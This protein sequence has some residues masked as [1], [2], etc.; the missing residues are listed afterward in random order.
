MAAVVHAKTSAKADGGDSTLVQPSDWNADHTITGLTTV[1]TDAIWD[2]A[3][4][5]AVGSGAD[6]AARLAKGAAG[7]VLAMG[8]GAVIWNAGTSFPASKA[9]GDRYYRTDLGMDFYY[10]GT[11]WLSVQ[12]FSLAGAVIDVLQP[13]STTNTS[14]TFAV[15]DEGPSSVGAYVTRIVFSTLV[16]GTN[17]GSHYWTVQACS[18]ASAGTLHNLGSSF[19][20]SADSTSWTRHVVSVG[21]VVTAGDIEYRAQGTKTG[22]PGGL[23]CLMAIYY[24]L[25][26]T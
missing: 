10:D 3:G 23:Y 12:E 19:A 14:A 13:V 15:V 8:N 9:T 7:A 22:T 6:T 16:T 1:A 17:T 5:L 24:R 26:A 2:A 4:D 25:I 18:M 20:T 11:R 21:S